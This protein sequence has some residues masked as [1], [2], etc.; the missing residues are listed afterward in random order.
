MDGSIHRAAGPLLLEE[1]KN[2]GGCAIGQAKLTKGYKLPAKYIIHTVGP[3]WRSGNK[4]ESKLL[5]SCYVSSL[6]LAEELKVEKMAFP[7]IS[8]GIYGYPV[9]QAA[10]IAIKETANFLELHEFPKE[11]IFVCFDE[12][13]YEA[14]QNAL[15]SL[16]H[17]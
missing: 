13:I 3:I 11:V 16:H 1:C 4:G 7:A 12:S 8:C 2:L 14:Y 10:M 6:R 17:E 9:S 15:D 5:A